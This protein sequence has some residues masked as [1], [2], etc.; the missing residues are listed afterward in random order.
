M[1]SETNKVAKFVSF[2]GEFLYNYT[3]NIYGDE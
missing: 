2:L 1:L 3:L